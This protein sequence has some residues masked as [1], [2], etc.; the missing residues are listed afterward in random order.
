MLLTV[1]L[2][3]VS[4]IHRTC[5]LGSPILIDVTDDTCL[6]PSLSWRLLGSIVRF[7]IEFRLVG[8]GWGEEVAS[9]W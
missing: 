5:P 8:L 7:P 6:S 4:P 3:I 2:H 9:G 1:K